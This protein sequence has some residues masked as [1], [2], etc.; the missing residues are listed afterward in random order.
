MALIFIHI[1]TLAWAK[2]PTGFKELAYTK[3]THIDF[4][5]DKKI[6][7]LRQYFPDGELKSY[8]YTPAQRRH[9]K[10]TFLRDENRVREVTKYFYKNK[11]TKKIVEN[12]STT[13]PIT[14]TTWWRPN[15]KGIMLAKNIQTVFPEHVRVQEFKRHKGQ[16]KLTSTTQKDLLTYRKVRKSWQF[17]KKEPKETVLDVYAQCLE[18]KQPHNNEYDCFTFLQ[19]ILSLDK[20][21]YNQLASLQCRKKNDLYLP[22]GFRIDLSTCQDPQLVS[23]IIQAT[24]D[25]LHKK[26]PCLN[27]MNPNLAQKFLIQLNK[28]RPIIHCTPNYETSCEV[29]RQYAPWRTFFNCPAYIENA[30][31]MTFQTLKAKPIFLTGY[32]EKYYALDRDSEPMKLNNTFENWKKKLTSSIFHESLHHVIKEGP[33]HNITQDQDPIIQTRFEVLERFNDAI[34]GCESLCKIG[35]KFTALSNHL[36]LM[37]CTSCL[38]VENNSFD[39]SNNICLQIFNPEDRFIEKYHLCEEEIRNKTTVQ[40]FCNKL[41]NKSLE[42]LKDCVKNSKRPCLD[43]PIISQKRKKLYDQKLIDELSLLKN[44]NPQRHKLIHALQGSLT[45]GHYI[46]KKPAPLSQKILSKKI[47]KKLNHSAALFRHFSRLKKSYCRENI[48]HKSIAEHN[49]KYAKLIPS[50]GRYAVIAKKLKIKTRDFE[51]IWNYHFTHHPM[52]NPSMS[53]DEIHAYCTKGAGGIYK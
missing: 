29:L 47:Q 32:L 10:E 50:F 37:G 23:Y 45:Q 8:V 31:A 1:A 14:K 34:Y 3:L 19:D 2:M 53:V 20:F 6:D 15:T 13:H 17:W 40:L 9:Y 39:P 4:N 18:K 27:A 22:N 42:Y 21:A 28:T 5:D 11:L 43:G 48:L 46:F 7:Y 26:L 36:T 49:A 30:G 33:Q 44:D 41:P 38:R 24:N 51:K 52:N 12:F 16:W 35:N 25:V